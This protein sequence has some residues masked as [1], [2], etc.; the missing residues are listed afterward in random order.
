MLNVTQPVGL[1]LRHQ[2]KYIPNSP[3]Q[4]KLLCRAFIV[5]FKVS[6]RLKVNKTIGAKVIRID[7]I[8]IKYDV[9]TLAYFIGFDQKVSKNICIQPIKRVIIINKWIVGLDQ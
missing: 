6:R 5:N 7:I 9:A 3:L 8:V 4:E 1:P 2:R